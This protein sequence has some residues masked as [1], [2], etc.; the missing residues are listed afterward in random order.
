MI[1]FGW[2]YS[3]K[4]PLLFILFIALRRII[5]FILETYVADKG[6]KFSYLMVTLMFIIETIIGS[7]FLLYKRIKNGPSL[8]SKFLGISMRKH[9]KILD[10][11]DKNFKIIL[12]IF[13]AAY[14]INVGA[15]SRRLIT[16]KDNNDI[17]DEYHAKYRSSEII[18]SSI[19]CFFTLRNKIYKHH[20]FALIII[21]I[22][23]IIVF[24]SGII[25]E[26]DDRKSL[27]IN[28]LITLVSSLCRSF[29]DTIEKYLF[30]YDFIDIYKLIVFEGWI[31]TLLSLTLFFLPIPQ[32]QIKKLFEVD[33]KQIFGIVGLLI[34]YSIFSGF[35]NIYRRFTVK[36]FT[37]MTRALA[38][39]I[40]DP[41]FIIYGFY[42]NKF[43]NMPNFI[44]TLICSFIMVF[45]SC[46]YNEIFVLYCFG[47]EY[48]T[49]LAVA[50]NNTSHSFLELSD[51]SERNSNI[52]N[53][54]L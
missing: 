1:K 15:L 12:L 47:L 37:P 18:I 50:N 52:D 31:E 11:P 30:Q 5:K 13:F 16:N 19:L 10:R 53:F 39:S 42:E 21:S 3:L 45:C 27:I 54:S 29:L 35:K 36:E 34:L 24:I 48:N 2:R 9:Y 49:H 26:K 33:I 17:Y 44:I 23:L 32:D 7:L 41:F 40:L 6:M 46:V 43:D 4:Y 25:L 8:N 20:I 14:F 38:E 51:D 28:I 22:C